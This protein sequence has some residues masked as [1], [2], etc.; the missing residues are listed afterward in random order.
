MGCGSA[1]GG[2]WAGDC[3]QGHG[4]EEDEAFSRQVEQAWRSQAHGLVGNFNIL[5]I[6]RRTG[7][8]GTGGAVWS[9][10]MAVGSLSRLLSKGSHCA[11][12]QLPKELV[13][14]VN[15]G[16]RLQESPSSEILRTPLGMAVSSLLQL[17]LFSAESVVSSSTLWNVLLI[18]WN[19]MGFVTKGRWFERTDWQC[20]TVSVAL[21]RVVS[22]DARAAASVFCLYECQVFSCFLHVSVGRSLYKGFRLPPEAVLFIFL[23]SCHKGE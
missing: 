8:Q 23:L 20:K 18:V 14:N 1:Q 15:V 16:S 21:H 6:C 9:S 13:G 12:P 7:Q 2:C 19:R 3:A 11:E 17:T 4:Q 5:G 22:A 10:G